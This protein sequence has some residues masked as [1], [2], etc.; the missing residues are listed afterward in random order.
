MSAQLNKKIV[1]FIKKNG[2]MTIDQYFLWCLSDPEFG[3]YTTC[4]PFGASGDFITAP[5]ISQMFGEMLAIFLVSA[6]EKHGFPQCVRLIEMGP[7]RGTMMVDILYAICKLRPSFFSV[8]SIHM[9]ENSERLKLIQQQ[10]LSSYGEKI[11]WCS[12]LSDVPQGCTFFIANE[13]FDSLPIK[14]FVTTKN[15][16]RE[17]MVDIDCQG[18]LIF[19]EGGQEV[20]RNFL[21]C[22]DC[23][24]GMIFE[25]SP[26]R[27]CQM[28]F[29]SDRLACE[30]G[31]AVIIDYGHFQ[32]S[33]GDTLQAVKGHEYYPLL[34]HSGQADLTSHVDFQRLSSIALSHKLYINGCITQGQ[35]LEG[36]GIWQRMFSLLRQNAGKKEI[37]LDAVKRLVGESSQQ[38]SMG[39]LF[40]V[41]VVSHK[42]IDL[43]PFVDS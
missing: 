4:N 18:E 27:D 6:W 25:T 26:Y 21:P 23:G 22:V 42:E 35:F 7:G 24:P 36:L 37:L 43:I 9:V 5:E 34:K 17:R 13:F 1:D 32:S 31:A 33:I 11:S 3:Y 12:S 10:Q 19:S 40:K 30:G 38:T 16:M 39:V 14:Q 2:P 15:G 20:E 41:L 8:L 28:K 29:I